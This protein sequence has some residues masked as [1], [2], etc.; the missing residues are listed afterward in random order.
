MLSVA[1]LIWRLFLKMLQETSFWYVHGIFW[2]H[3]LA[4][5]AFWNIFSSPEPKAQVSYC[6][7]TP[8]VH[9]RAC[10]LWNFMSLNG[11]RNADKRANSFWQFLHFFSRNSSCFYYVGRQ[12]KSSDCLDPVLSV[13]KFIIDIDCLL[14][15]NIDF[16]NRES[17]IAKWLERRPLDSGVMSS[18]PGLYMFLIKDY[19]FLFPCLSFFSSISK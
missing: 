5:I 1:N 15:G 2:T 3:F 7:S 6:H 11:H 10:L 18:S 14:I 8:S 16:P 13:L 9:L 4:I 17:S 19:F 12:T